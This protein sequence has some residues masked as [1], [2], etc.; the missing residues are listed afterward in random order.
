MEGHFLYFQVP[1]LPKSTAKIQYIPTPRIHTFFTVEK[2]WEGCSKLILLTAEEWGSAIPRRQS[3][4]RTSIPL[5]VPWTCHLRALAVRQ[6]KL[7][8]IQLCFLLTLETVKLLNVAYSF[9]LVCLSRGRRL[10]MC[11]AYYCWKCVTDFSKVFILSRFAIFSFL[12]SSV[13]LLQSRTI[14]H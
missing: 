8:Y 4:I 1:A 12:K 13:V 11:H 5:S 7:S 2:T 6:H 9:Q 3:L 10:L 14:A